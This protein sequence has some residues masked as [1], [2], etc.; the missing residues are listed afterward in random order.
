MTIDERHPQDPAEGS[1]ETIEHEL[2]AQETNRRE[3]GARK[4]EARDEP[5]EEEIDRPGFDL[6]G[7]KDRGQQKLKNPIDPVGKGGEATGRADG[8]S[9]TSGS[10]PLG[11][12]VSG[13]A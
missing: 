9:D 1:R 11:R 4:L 3:T 5:A 12:N 13:K 2:Q 10:R 6:G 8:F 7:A